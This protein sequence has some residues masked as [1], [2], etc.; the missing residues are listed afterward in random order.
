[1]KALDAYNKNL[2]GYLSTTWLKI[3]VSRSEKCEA[4][5]Q[6]FTIRN[7]DGTYIMWKLSTCIMRK[8]WVA[9]FK[10]Y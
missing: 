5:T 3:K 8:F 9:C 10:K 4:W 1:M 7:L 6:S 2:L